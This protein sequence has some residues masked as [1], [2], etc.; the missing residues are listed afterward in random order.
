MKI[1]F[2]IITIGL[3]IF[4]MEKELRQ[5]IKESDLHKVE[6]LLAGNKNH[7]Q[8]D[9]SSGLLPRSGVNLQ[10]IHYFAQS[11]TKQKAEL[12]ESRN[13][14]HV[15]K[16]ALL[17]ITSMGMGL[18][19]VSYYFYQAVAQGKSESM[20]NFLSILV[21]AGGLAGH[22]AEQFRLGLGNHDAINSHAK[23]AAILQAIESAR[24]TE[25][26]KESA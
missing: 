1:L 3:P 10:Q 11:L 4:G 13:N 7:L 26:P 12:K 19:I 15:Y 22:G 9:D 6:T 5:A 23:H 21:A 24:K 16:R 14:I 25:S 18:A 8:V 2:F 17:G 20:S